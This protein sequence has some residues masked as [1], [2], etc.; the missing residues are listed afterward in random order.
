MISDK[1][2]CFLTAGHCGNLP[3]YCWC[4]D[5]LEN[6]HMYCTQH[7]HTHTHIHT[8]IHSQRPTRTDTHTN[9]HKHTQTYINTQTHTHTHTTTHINTHTQLH[10]THTQLHTTTYSTNTH[11]QRHKHTH[12]Q[13]HAA[14]I[15]KN[16]HRETLEQPN[17]YVCSFTFSQ[18]CFSCVI[19][20]SFMLEG[21]G[22]MQFNVPDSTRWDGIQMPPPDKQ[23]RRNIMCIVCFA[24]QYRT[25][26]H[27]HKHT[28]THLHTLHTQNTQKL[29]THTKYKRAHKM[30]T[31]PQRHINTGCNT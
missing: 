4:W 28:G 10:T 5:K 23:V 20:L 6:T 26:T 15:H 30:H 16:T 25:H 11:K 24:A 2:G 19:I 12:S 27:T 9:T 13:A 31:H 17:S 22:V 14:W 8:N 3:R 1:H 21:G 29:L 18:I 7:K